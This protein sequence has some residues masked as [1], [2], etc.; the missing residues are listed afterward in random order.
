MK[1]E[2]E[3]I[4]LSVRNYGENNAIIVCFTNN[5][6]RHAG[7]VRQAY[8]A[9]QNNALEPGMQLNL[10]WNAR[11]N[12]HLG[13]FLIDKIKSRTANLIQTKQKLLGFNSL[14][15]LL[16]ISLPERESFEKLYKATV[17]LVDMMETEKSWVSS[18]VRWELLLLAEL[19]FGL[20][21]SECA[22]TG[23]S[24]NL[25]YVSPKSGRAV[26]SSAGLEWKNKLL[27]LPEFLTISHD[28]V[29]RDLKHIHVG[30]A[31]TGYFLE[32]WLMDSLAKPTLP[33]ARNRFFASLI[34]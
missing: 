6:G 9:K 18:Y 22:L 21:L 15:S 13:I 25:A 28:F 33:E 24:L 32:K 19:G 34:C 10:V 23:E 5:H 27:C 16:L 11:L 26:S 7:M 20:D 17:N 14:I 2:D 4:L 30:M 12:E 3:G 8:S 1:W 31:L 29:E